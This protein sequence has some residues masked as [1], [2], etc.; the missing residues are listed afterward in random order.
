MFN[1][2]KQPIAILVEN[3]KAFDLLRKRF[4]PHKLIRGNDRFL[5]ET[6]Y[7]GVKILLLETGMGEDSINYR[8][9]S[10]FEKYHDI[11][12]AVFLGFMGALEK[13]M[14]VGD[15]IIPSLFV[16][17]SNPG[18]EYRSNPELLNFCQTLQDKND[19]KLHLGEKNLTVDRVYLG[20]DKIRLKKENPGVS[21]ID[22]EA[23]RMAK[24]FSEKKIPFIVSKAVSDEWCFAFRDFESLFDDEQKT[25]LA[26][27]FI[28]CFRY[29]KEILNLI[30]LTINIRKALENNI[31]FLGNLL[32]R[33]V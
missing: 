18:Q 21:S 26:K 17:I 15:I 9:S 24:R 6:D 13:N 27:L 5:F 11:G 31:R 20:E 1:V 22:M 25:N 10:L 19:F 3:R 33:L 28:Y 4:S 23:F 14:K 12:F 29:P 32:E 2:K 16:S 30:N 7:K 8:I